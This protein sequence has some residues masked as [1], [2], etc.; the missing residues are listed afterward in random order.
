MASVAPEVTAPAAVGLV[1]VNVGQPS[2]IGTHRGEPIV[3]GIEKRPVEVTS[4]HLDTTNLAGD[5]QADLRV[6]GGPDKAVYAYPSEHLPRWS[7][8]LDRDPPFGPGA[9]GENLTVAGWFED[10][11][12]IGDVWTWG[13]AILQVAQPRYPCYKLATATGVPQMIKLLVANARTGWYLRVLRPGEVPVAGPI[14]V[15]ERDPAGVTVREAHLARLPEASRK[16]VERVAS[17]R[18]LAGSMREG[19]LDRLA[20]EV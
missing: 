1:S 13:E 8:E 17:V 3:S 2:V 15:T 18:A 4:L 14:A 5:R 10:E 9:F 19:L 7:A 16:L 11:V 20:R 12:R 6:H